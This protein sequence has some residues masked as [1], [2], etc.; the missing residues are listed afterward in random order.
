VNSVPRRVVPFLLVLG[1]SLTS[2]AAWALNGTDLIKQGV[3][4]LRDGKPQ[5]ALDIFS[6]ARQLEPNS[7]K[8]HYYIASA[9]ERLNNADS[10]RA[11][12]DTAIRMDPKY[13]E[14]LTGLG[15]LL[16]KQGKIPE[17]TEKLE[18]AV[19]YDPKDPAALYSLGTA[20]L[21]DKKYDEA[22]KVFRKGTLL[23][24][25]RAQF[26]AGTAL[27]LEGKG[28]LK[29]AE[30]IFIRARET[31]PNNLRVRLELGGFYERK[32]IP[33]LAVPEYKKAKE[34]EPKNAEYHYLYGRASVGMNEFN[35]GLRAFVE[36]NNV[37]ST[38][39][40]AY[41][42]SG[43][44]FYRAKRYPEAVEK[45]QKYVELMP[46]DPQGAL[47]LG[48]SLSYSRDPAERAMAIGSL[49]KALEKRPDDKEILGTLCK[50]YSAQGDEGRDNAMKVCT[51]YADVADTL[52]PEER[53]RIGII[54]AS[55]GDTTRAVP[56]LESAAR[57][58]T[59]FARDANFNLGFLYFKNQE[60]AASVP[61]FEKT[62]QVDP[63]FVPALLN[64]G[65]AKM[66]MKQNSEA[67]GYLRQAVALKPND[68]TNAVHARVWVGQ[69][70]MQMEA[71]SLPAALQSFQ[72]AAAADSANGDA[73]RGAG[74]AY[75]LMDNCANALDW[76]GRGTQVEPEHVQGHIWLAQGYL[77]CKNIPQA[78]VEFNKALE[79]D[80]TNRPASD[81]LN[82]IRKYEDQQQ[83]AK[84]KRAAQSSSPS[85]SGSKP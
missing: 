42:E 7:P 83:A 12:Y 5:Q 71:D 78:K 75:L 80:P 18:L 27:A 28:Q 51:K 38:Y 65:L 3:T 21:K 52:A 54:F 37:D 31:D 49:E 66:Q 76:L 2:V 25:G 53:L 79:I 24:T 29:E 20:Y 63:E 43:R 39:A 73:L 16:R 40:P 48:R 50:L 15:N 30:E 17:G 23:K 59:S 6:R 4:A 34:L 11:E 56:L 77:K 81:G 35:E 84:Q 1:L 47:E 44:L 85:T 82:L 67:I 33:F 36:A 13:V 61:Y 22:E 46:D 69:I 55:L 68:K 72:E 10:A 58:D 41:L 9:L 14:A 60:Y 70:L 19:K 26:L 64:L 45:F 8:P 57:E 62:I 74:L 32:K